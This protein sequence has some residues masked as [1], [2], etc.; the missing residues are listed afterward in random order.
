MG[1]KKP[2]A[3]KVTEVTKVTEQTS[4]REEANEK[5]MGKKQPQESGFQ[6]SIRH[7]LLPGAIVKQ[8]QE[9]VSS[10]AACWPSLVIPQDG[11]PDCQP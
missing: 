8:I 4:R 6:K 5:A 10:L 3:T 7:G 1:F 11:M 9:T 2:S